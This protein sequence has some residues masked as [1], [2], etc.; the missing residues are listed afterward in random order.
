MKITAMAILAVLMSSCTATTA[1]KRSPGL[2]KGKLQ[3]CPSSPNCVCSEYRQDKKHYTEPISFNDTYNPDM[4]IG[5]AKTVILEMGGEIKSM[6]E[7][8]MAAI[9]KSSVFRFIDDFEVRIDMGKR[10]LHIRSASRT[11]YSDLGVNRRRVK[12]FKKKFAD[13]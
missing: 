6:E 2:S 9:F 5:K 4:V 13:Q 11:G 8:Y 12:R 10:L 1:M 7:M 3:K